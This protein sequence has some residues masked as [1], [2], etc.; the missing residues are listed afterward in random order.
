MVVFVLKNAGKDD[1]KIYTKRYHDSQ[2]KYMEQESTGTDYYGSSYKKDNDDYS[3]YTNNDSTY[4]SYDTTDC[5]Y[6]S[7]SY[8]S[9]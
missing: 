5:T 8:D 3:G 1:P 9:D 4:S 2:K 7:C 6:Y